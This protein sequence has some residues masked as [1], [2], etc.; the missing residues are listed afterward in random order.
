[1]VNGRL[2]PDYELAVCILVLHD[3]YTTWLSQLS[4]GSIGIFIDF[5]NVYLI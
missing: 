4:T 3:L 2:Y 5:I 1:M